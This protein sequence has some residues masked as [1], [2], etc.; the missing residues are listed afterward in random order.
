VGEVVFASTAAVY[1]KVDQSLMPIKETQ[2]A[3]PNS[4]YG[5]TKLMNEQFLKIYEGKGIKHTI[6]RFF[7]VMGADES[8]RFGYNTYP[9]EHLMQS[10]I[11]NVLGMYPEFKLTYPQVNTRDGSTIRD[12][13]HVSDIAHA[14]RLGLE[15]HWS[16]EG[17]ET[18][19]IMNLGSEK[20][21]S[22]LEI[23]NA[24]EAQLGVQI[25]RIKG[26]TRPG[27]D[28]MT[29]ADPSK[30]KRVLGWM[31]ERTLDE[32]IIGLRDWFMSREFVREVYE[33]KILREGQLPPGAKK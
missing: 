9:P 8:G 28:P 29:I 32:G 22:T 33:P 14:I 17:R 20:G 5:I 18:S 19:E 30:A 13:I 16:G 6:L 3:D 21:Q 10:A 27:E 7:N 23:I 25:P 24:V 4:V 31:P 2:P 11:L 12:Y 1:G 15:R 26:E